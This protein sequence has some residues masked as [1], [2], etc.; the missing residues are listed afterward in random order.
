MTILRH[1]V[2]KEISIHALLAESDSCFLHVQTS[3]HNFNPRSPCGERPSIFRTSVCPKNFNPRS[4]CGERPCHRGLRPVPDQFQST[5]SLRRATDGNPQSVAVYGISIHALLAE[6]DRIAW[7]IE[8]SGLTNFNPRSPHGERHIR[9]RAAGSEDEFQSTLSSR[10]AT[11][12]RPI[13]GDA[14]RISIHALLTESDSV[15]PGLRTP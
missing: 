2:G 7:V 1:K 5:L 3:P 4:P 8:Q 10:R 11:A 6:S 9:G 14:L 13:D 15:L 12:V